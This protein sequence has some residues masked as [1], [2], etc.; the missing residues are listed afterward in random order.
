M[1]T[2]PVTPPST[3][4]FTQCT[5]R[6]VRATSMSESPYSFQQ[7]VYE[8]F[9]AR[10]EADCQ[11]PPMSRAQAADWQAF[12]LS[13]RG[14]SGTFLMGKTAEASP[15]GTATAAVTNGA[16]FVRAATLVVDGMGNAKTL[17]AGDYFE[18]ASHLYQ[19]IQNVTSDASG[20]ATL[21]FEP[22]LRANVA[23]NTA[24]VLTN[25][26]GLWRMTDDRAS[27][28]M[29]AAMTYNMNYS[30]VEAL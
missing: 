18:I 21:T 16:A 4:G 7:Q 13:L 26:K 29:D 8:H 20:N 10:W 30:C 6:L 25:P 28:N 24:L 19:I 17:L 3:P 9:G 22:F 11:L 15:R 27:W 12:M 2:Y 14:R 5:M 1:T 23:D